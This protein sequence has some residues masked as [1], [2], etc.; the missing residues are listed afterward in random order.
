MLII[1]MIINKE[2]NR[3]VE[4]E[5]FFIKGILDIDCQYFIEKIKES[6]S[7][8]DN[9]NYVTNILGLMTPY[10]F[11]VNDEKFIKEIAHPLMDYVDENYKQISYSLR[12]AWGFELRPREKTIF[13]DHHEALWSAVVYLNDCEQNLEFKDIE[14]KCKPQKGAFCIFSS[15]LSHG[16]KKNTDTISKFGMSLNFNELKP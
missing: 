6:C 8:K 7:S 9:N 2:I 12:D 15:F 14:Q 16:C 1:I 5:Y 3:K 11:F 13:H 10:N 4:K